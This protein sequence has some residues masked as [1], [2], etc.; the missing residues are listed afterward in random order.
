MARAVGAYHSITADK[1]FQYLET[2]RAKAKH[3]E[4][5]ALGHARKQSA[6]ERDIHWQ[7]VIA[8]VVAEK[9][10]ALANEKAE[11]EKLRQQ[12]ATLQAGQ[13]S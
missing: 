1:Q 3:D 5:Q 9:D 6:K 11:N 13:K 8:E 10:T 12:L 2:L 4:A 7:N